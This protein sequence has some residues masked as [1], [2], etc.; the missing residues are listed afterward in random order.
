[1]AAVWKLLMTG[2]AKRGVCDGLLF[3]GEG[4]GD[5]KRGG[6][7]TLFGLD[8]YFF[9]IINFFC[10]P[11]SRT[12]ASPGCGCARNSRVVVAAGEGG[13]RGRIDRRL[14]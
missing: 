1:M 6:V 13:V 5:G 4:G 3:R 10:P 12:E 14:H 11:F 8:F 2:G 7:G 9:F